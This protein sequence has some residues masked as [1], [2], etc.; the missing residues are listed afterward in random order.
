MFVRL[1]SRI[2]RD[3]EEAKDIVREVYARLISM[4]GWASIANPRL[5]AAK[6]VRNLAL[7]RA[8]RAKIVQF[9]QFSD[10]TDFDVI[11]DSPSQHR[12]VAAQDLMQRIIRAVDAMPERCR[13]ALLLRR[14][15]NRSASEAALELGISISTLE[16]RLARSIVLLTQALGP[17]SDDTQELEPDVTGPGCEQVDMRQR[18]RAATG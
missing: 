18:G 13:A 8:R 1:A 10:F 6:M 16:K 4:E 7:E 9:K 3:S 17:L 2:E 11:D 15:S 12:V 14:F 5:Y